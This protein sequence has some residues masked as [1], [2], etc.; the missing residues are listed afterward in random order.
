MDINV[1]VIV[2]II[3]ARHKEIKKKKLRHCLYLTF[4]EGV[5]SVSTSKSQ[6]SSKAVSSR[7]RENKRA[8]ETRVCICCVISESR[9]YF[10]NI[11]SN[12]D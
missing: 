8:E 11:K 12:Y 1:L 2:C 5:A 3:T 4:M 10:H 7:E 9:N 6:R